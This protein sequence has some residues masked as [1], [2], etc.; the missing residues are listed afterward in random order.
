VA[1]GSYMGFEWAGGWVDPPLFL[2]SVFR[3]VLWVFS[4][5]GGFFCVLSVL[6][7]Y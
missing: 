5:F 6:F 3:G 1:G 2:G 4:L 7:C